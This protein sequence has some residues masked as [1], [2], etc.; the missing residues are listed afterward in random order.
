MVRSKGALRTLAVALLGRE[1]QSSAVGGAKHTF[2]SRWVSCAGRLHRL[3]EG[4]TPGALPVQIRQPAG[5]LRKNPMSSSHVCLRIIGTFVTHHNRARSSLHGTV[6]SA[7]TVKR[8][9]TG[10]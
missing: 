10:S 5:A 7:A 3:D 4:P 1:V 8:R 2:A 6:E 9:G